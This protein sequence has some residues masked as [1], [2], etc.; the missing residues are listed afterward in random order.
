MPSECFLIFYGSRMLPFYTFIA[1]SRSV[2]LETKV[3]LWL[4]TN[5]GPHINRAPQTASQGKDMCRTPTPRVKL[6]EHTWGKKGANRG[7]WGGHR[8]QPPPSLS[9]G[10]QVA[11]Q[12]EA[13]APSHNHH[14]AELSVTQQYWPGLP[15][16]PMTQQQPVGLF[17]GPKANLSSSL[18]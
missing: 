16:P 4:M 6:H 18:Y 12:G 8:P 2:R 5:S 9:W 7:G 17:P 11:S 15:L 1:L 14:Q 13:R 3:R 10:Q